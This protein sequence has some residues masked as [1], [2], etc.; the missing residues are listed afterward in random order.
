MTISVLPDDVLLEIFNLHVTRPQSYSYVSREGPKLYEDAWHTLVHVCQ[1]WRSVVFS[2]PRRLNLR[3]F[4]TNKRPIEKMPTIW[5][6]LPIIIYAYSE[7]SLLRGVSNLFTALGQHNRICKIDICGIPNSLLKQFGAMKKPFPKLTRLDLRSHDRSAPVIPNSF[8]GGCAPRLRRLFLDGIP[9]PALPKLLLSCHDLVNLQLWNI[10]PSG[11]IPPDSMV[12]CVAALKSLDLLD[13]KFRSPRS[14]ADRESRRPSPYTRVVLPTLTRFYF[15]GDSDCLEDIISR[16]DVPLL[17]HIVI[18]FFNQLIF[19]TPLLLHFISRTENFKTPQ[20]ADIQFGDGS[21]SIIIFWPDAILN[22]QID[23]TISCRPSDWQLSSLA[24]VWSSALSPLLTLD[25]L[26]IR[27]HREHWQDDMEITQWLELLRPFVSV[28]HLVLSKKL[29]QLLAPALQVIAEERMMETLPALE[30]LSL[31]GLHPSGPVKEAIGTYIAARRLFSRP[32]TV[33]HFDDEG[34]K[35][36][37]NYD[38]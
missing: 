24:Q 3:L 10:S 13:L 7:T 22:S 27:D 29:V 35:M 2:S 36:Y 18:K 25:L 6:T 5:P 33:D 26:E 8:L 23:L 15:Q 11:Y 1:K 14:R 20:S 21:V 37:E 38:R 19:D 31:R 4:C 12:T 30:R 28:K 32:I 16:I 9:F 17:R 34:S